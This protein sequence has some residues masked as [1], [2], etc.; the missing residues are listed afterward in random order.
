MLLFTT[1]TTTDILVAG[2]VVVVVVVVRTNKITSFLLSEIPAF[3][4][5]QKVANSYS[6]RL[7]RFCL[8]ETFSLGLMRIYLSALHGV[9][10]TYI[11]R[12]SYGQS[13]V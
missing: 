4:I 1:T 9:A 3:L 8:S 12:K 13:Y 5:L 10:G 11:A 6:V 7:T 2:S